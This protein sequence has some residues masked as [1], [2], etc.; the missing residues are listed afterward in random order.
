MAA[1]D[2]K[3]STQVNADADA[4]GSGADQGA[5][6]P[7]A[8]AKSRQF[9]LMVHSQEGAEN[10]DVLVG[11][12]GRLVQIKRGVEVIVDEAYVEAL[13]N[14]RIDTFAKDPDTGKE[15]PVSIMRYAFEA[16]PV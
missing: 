15:T 2:T 5:D 1:P 16:T 13:R 14:A 11:V 12:N 9:K 3:D 7:K 6:Q 8:V 4:A 10:S